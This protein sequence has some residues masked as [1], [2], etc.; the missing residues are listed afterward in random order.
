VDSHYKLYCL[1]DDAGICSALVQTLKSLYSVESHTSPSDCLASACRD[2]CDFLITDIKMPKMNGIELITKF[3]KYFPFAP[4]VIITGYANVNL[5]KKGIQAGANELLEKPFE[6]QVL[7][8]TV[9]ELLA[10]YSILKTLEK[11]HCLT[12]M[13]FMTL[14]QILSGRS[15]KEMSF[16]LKRSIRT[17]ESHRYGLM[18]KCGVNNIMSLLTKPGIVKYIRHKQKTEAFEINS[19]TLT[20][21]AVR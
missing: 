20:Q 16:L 4:I 6:R 2:G 17:L 19:T 14:Q 3:R 1:D 12:K 10:G 8:K 18:K 13:E 7:L 5:A 11:E 21:A 15:T 9:E